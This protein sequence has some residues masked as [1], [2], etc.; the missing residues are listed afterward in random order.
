M[1]YDKRTYPDQFPSKLAELVVGHRVVSARGDSITLDRGVTVTLE[2]SSDCCA[3]GNIEVL[4]Q[5][6]A[7][8]EHVVTSVAE[9]SEDE[10]ATWFIMADAHQVLQLSGEWD[11]SNGYYFYGFYI[12]VTGG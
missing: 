2:G 5:T 12:T 9:S 4:A 6:L 1:H 7:N 10:S 8:T 3:W 11:P